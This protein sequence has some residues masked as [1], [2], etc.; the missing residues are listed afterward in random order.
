MKNVFILFLLSFLFMGWTNSVSAQSKESM[1][2][3]KF[4]TKFMGSVRVKKKGKMI[5]MIQKDYVAQHLDG[6]HKGDKN[7][8]LA[9]FMSGTV[10]K[11]GEFGRVPLSKIFDIRLKELNELQ[12]GI[13]ECKFILTTPEG[14]VETV[15]YLKSLA[16]KG[17]FAFEPQRK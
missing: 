3:Q 9:Q 13:A 15:L 12:A 1:K 16:K 10:I 8:F 4:V 11:S 2:R 7:A 17:K 5:R 14:D 6:T